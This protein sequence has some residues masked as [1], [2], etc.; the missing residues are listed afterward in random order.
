MGCLERGAFGMAIGER[1]E[2]VQ[3][4]RFKFQKL[5]APLPRRDFVNLANDGV[6]LLRKCR[7]QKLAIKLHRSKSGI[8]P[9]APGGKIIY[10]IVENRT[11]KRRSRMR[12]DCG[13]LQSRGLWSISFGQG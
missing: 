12:P 6:V 9:L 11:V 2:E 8:A 4:L 13:F 1:A 7:E 3:H 10:N 5:A